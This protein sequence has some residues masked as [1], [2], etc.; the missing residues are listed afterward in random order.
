MYIAVGVFIAV[1]FITAVVLIQD[2]FDWLEG[3]ND[4]KD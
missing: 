1:V 2:N 3:I 4:E